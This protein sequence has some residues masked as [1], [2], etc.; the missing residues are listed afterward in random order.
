LKYYSEKLSKL[1]DSEKELTEAETAEVN[2]KKA[3]ETRAKE[4]EDAL[5]AAHEASDHAH[6]LLTAFCKDYGS[7][8]TTIK[9]PDDLDA[10]SWIRDLLLPF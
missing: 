5:A 2:K 7:Y 1:F 8:H 10:F 9:D 4:V 3:R 6:K